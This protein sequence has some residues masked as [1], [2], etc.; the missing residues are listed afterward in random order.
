MLTFSW[1]VMKANAVTLLPLFANNNSPGIILFQS[2]PCFG[3]LQTM[4]AHSHICTLTVERSCVVL[5]KLEGKTALLWLALLNIIC[6]SFCQGT[7]QPC[8]LLRCHISSQHSIN[9]PGSLICGADSEQCNATMWFW[10]CETICVIKMRSLYTI[11][12]KAF[13]TGLTF[14]SVVSI[15]L[16]VQRSTANLF[17]LCW[18]C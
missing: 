14:N 8:R 6:V 16:W 1:Q 12:L 11:L 17:S 15:S 18:M 2:P 7:H 9:I 4:Q 10:F 5:V 13:K 3:I